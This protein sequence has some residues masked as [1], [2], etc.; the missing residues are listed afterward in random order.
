MPGQPTHLA[1]ELNVGTVYRTGMSQNK[2]KL[3]ADKTELLV[4]SSPQMQ[5]KISIPSITVHGH[6]VTDLNEPVDNLGAV[7]DP[8][9]NMPA[10]VSNVIK[11]ANYHLRNIGKIRKF[12][13]TDTFDFQ[14][15][16][17]L[18]PSILYGTVSQTSQYKDFKIKR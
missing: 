11:T 18:F 10:H 1:Q 14:M 8:N 2:L 3:N 7:F 15:Q 17:K 13:N 12:H 9:I 4:M 6:I 5:A 16:A